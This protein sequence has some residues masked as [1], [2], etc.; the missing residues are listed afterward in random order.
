MNLLRDEIAHRMCRR[1]K[2]LKLI[3]QPLFVSSILESSI[4]SSLQQP[5]PS[6]SLVESTNFVLEST[7]D[8]TPS[9]IAV[10]SFKLPSS[11]SLTFSKSNN[12]SFPILIGLFACFVGTAFGGFACL[13]NPC[14]FGVCIDDLNR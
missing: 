13:S 1:R 3:K 12:L 10:S 2:N 6:A 14:L 4:A 5:S 7:I 8:A 11:K 9:P